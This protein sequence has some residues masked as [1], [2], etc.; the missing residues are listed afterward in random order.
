MQNKMRPLPI[1]SKLSEGAGVEIH[2]ERCV[3]TELQ[4]ELIAPEAYM[5]LSELKLVTTAQ[6]VF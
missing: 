1:N 5:K 6:N 3:S 4:H 2:L